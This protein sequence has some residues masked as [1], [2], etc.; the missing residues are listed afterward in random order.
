VKINGWGTGFLRWVSYIV[1]VVIVA[2]WLDSRYITRAD[3][4][5]LKDHAD[6]THASIQ[7]DVDLLTEQNREFTAAISRLN[8][9]LARLNGYLNRKDIP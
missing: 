9:E 4:T 5:L 7:K 6:L 3:V 2:L 1:P 8:V